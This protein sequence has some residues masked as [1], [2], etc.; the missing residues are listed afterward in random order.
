MSNFCF[1]LTKYPKL[2]LLQDNWEI[3]RE[4][5]QLVKD[6]L[7]KMPYPIYDYDG[8]W[9]AFGFAYLGERINQDICPRVNEILDEMEDVY[10]AGFSVLKPKVVINPHEGEGAGYLRS[11]VGLICPDGCSITVGGEDYTWS[12]GE[13]VVFDGTIEHSARNTSDDERVVFLLDF[14][15]P[16]ESST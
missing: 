12:E 14:P 6:N 15:V 4:E 1:D 16:N 5:Y 2:K 13:V 9:A 8:T 11:H 7:I 10:I 3:F